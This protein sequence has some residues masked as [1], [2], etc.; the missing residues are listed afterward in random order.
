MTNQ[1][2]PSRR[3]HV[4]AEVQGALR[5]AVHFRVWAPARSRVEVVVDGRAHPM[6][7]DP[8]RKG[9]FEAT[10]D[11]VRAGSRYR[12]RLDGKDEFPDPASRSQPEGPHGPSEV[13]DPATYV[14]RDRGWRGTRIQ[15]A[16]VYELHFGT[17][18]REG[19]YAAAAR[20]LPRLKELGITLLEVMPIAEFPGAFGWGYD[21]VD[22]YAPAHVYGSPDDLRRFVDEAHAHGLG[23]ILDV[24]YNHFGPDGC[25][26]RELSSSYFTS[27]YT[28]DW[29]ESIN[30][31]GDDSGPVRDLVVANAGYWID[32]F[33]FDGLRL[34]ATQS[35]HDASPNHLIAAIAQRAREAAENGRSI[36]LVAENEPQDAR[37]ARS[38]ADGGYGL[39]ALWNDDFHHSASVAA[40]G[41]RE[42]YYADTHGTPQELIAAVKW[43]FLFQGQRYAWQ[44]GARG[45]PAFDLLST[46]FVTFLENHDQVA[47]GARG[48]RLWQRTSPAKH[49][50]LVALLLLA[51]QTPMLFQGE[52]FGS[53]APFLFFADHGEELAKLVAKGRAEFL[54]Q[55]PSMDNEAT[56]RALDSPS[57]RATF[58]KCKLDAGER[59]RNVHVTRFYRDLLRLRR[60]DPA[61]AMQ[62]G[63][64]IHGTVLSEDAFALRYFC[65][66]GDRLVVV[67]LGRELTRESIADPI[68]APPRGRHWQVILSTEDRAYGGDGV[69]P[70]DGEDGWRIGG[71]QTTV[72]APPSGES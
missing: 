56:R 25:Y 71:Q 16:V 61:F 64:R 58:E 70:A 29:G 59:D 48:E 55:F 27:R 35:I 17:L 2:H 39:D 60:D 12:Y 6:R 65:D 5:D 46:A 20:E 66:G 69:G 3:I 68:I 13:V 43:G 72:L 10:V 31:D 45:A 37:L 32:E 7:T 28:N 36:V 63:D 22:L 53:S 8:E 54:S 40:T 14:W 33:H 57:A 34:D 38:A 19:T 21:G 18:T 44:E 11:G 9:Y 47:N 23:V 30:Y 26:L 1:A 42:A 49:R 50:A 4:G 62:R 24:V 67:N 41:Q 15:G 51:P 52:E